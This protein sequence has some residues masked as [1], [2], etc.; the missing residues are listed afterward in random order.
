MTSGEL[1]RAQRC[2]AL[3]FAA[4]LGGTLAVVSAIGRDWIP[5]AVGLVGAV[6]ALGVHR[7]RCRT[8]DADEA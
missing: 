2:R 4:V 6:V 5:A 7:R 8:I 3:V 1:A